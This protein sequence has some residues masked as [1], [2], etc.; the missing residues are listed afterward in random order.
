VTSQLLLLANKGI[1]TQIAQDPEV[2]DV[3]IG[4]DREN[5]APQW[6]HLGGTISMVVS[7][8]PSCFVSFKVEVVNDSINYVCQSALII[9]G[10]HSNSDI[11]YW[12][13]PT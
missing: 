3:Y 7:E 1:K 12:P 13:L 6:E 10:I 5:S 11:V 8:L 2:H 4:L 9:Y